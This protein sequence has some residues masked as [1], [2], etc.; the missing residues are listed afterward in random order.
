MEAPSGYGK[1]TALRDYLKASVPQDTDV[2]WFTAVEEAPDA[3]F[4]RLCRE[5]E[6]ID[7]RYTEGW[8]I[9]VYLQ[10]RTYRE[11]GAFSDTVV[12]RLMEGLVWDRLKDEQRTLYLRL[13]PFEN[14][15]VRQICALLGSN[16]LPEFALSCLSGPFIRYD[17][18][19]RRYEPH[20][21]LVELLAQKR[22][23]RGT[24]FE[25]ECL[26]GAGDVC[27]DEGHTLEALGFYYRAKDYQ[28]MLSLDLSRSIFEEVG[29]LTFFDIALD[30]ARECPEAIRRDC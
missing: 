20:A 3:L 12:L 21:I 22:A 27:R 7:T 4:R 30:I 10:L 14:A 29:D 8:I 28:R 26:L 11:T 18:G 1:T 13:S 24:P 19:Q 2:Y 23:E 9:A 17:A 15:T 16:A 5:I 25:R 6:K